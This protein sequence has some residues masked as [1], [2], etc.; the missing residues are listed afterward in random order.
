MEEFHDESLARSYGR[1][2]KACKKDD[3]VKPKTPNS[4]S[5]PKTKNVKVLRSRKDNYSY[6]GDRCPRCNKRLVSRRGKYGSFTGCSGY[7][8]CN[9]TR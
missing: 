6:S 1:I 8:Y 7:P 5:E 2:C 4:S 3:Y 9:Y